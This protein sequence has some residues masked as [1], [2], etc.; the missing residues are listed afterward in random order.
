M[1]THSVSTWGY[2]WTWKRKQKL[3][4]HIAAMTKRWRVYFIACSRASS[5]ADT[6]LPTQASLR[7]F[8]QPTT[9]LGWFKG[10]YALQI[11]GILW[12]DSSPRG[13]QLQPWQHLGFSHVQ[14]QWPTQNTPALYEVSDPTRACRP[15][16]LLSFWGSMMAEANQW[17][18][19]NGRNHSHTS[20][21]TN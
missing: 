21:L 15:I 17:M 6:G 13:S 18:G 7:G 10:T 11:L 2:G 19:E 5:K 20:L 14:R 12:W 9:T 8:Q 1:R 16:F 3:R 4:G